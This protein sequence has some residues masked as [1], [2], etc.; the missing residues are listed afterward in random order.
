MPMMWEAFFYSFGSIF[1]AEF[2]DKT[3]LAIFLL[4]CRYGTGR[5]FSGAAAAFTLLNAL[6]VGVGAIAL[7]LIPEVPLKIAVSAIF[8]LLGLLS[9]KEAFS[10]EEEEDELE[11]RAARLLGSG[12][13]VLQV[14]LLVSLMELGDKTQLALAGLSARYSQPIP[15][16]IGGTAALWITSFLGAFLGEKIG[17]SL[18][19]KALKVASGMLFMAFGLFFLLVQL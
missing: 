2:G 6:A 15:V 11:E 14:F 1:A 9:L 8:F 13:P 16:F 12:R 5:V 3:Q 10:G 7:R 19:R 18:P 4:A 17:H